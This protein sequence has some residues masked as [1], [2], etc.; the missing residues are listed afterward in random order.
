MKKVSAIAGAFSH[1]RN[2]AK[3]TFQGWM[4]TDDVAQSK[5][6]II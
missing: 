4:V 1:F 2:C 3:R 5:S 6:T